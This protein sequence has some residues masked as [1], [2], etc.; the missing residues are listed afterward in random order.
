[1][2]GVTE[3]KCGA[4]TETM[5]MQRLPHLGSIPYITT[6]PRHYCG[7]QQELADRSLI[8]M[9]SERLC[10]CLTNTEV[11]A[12]SHLLDGA[13]GPQGRSYRRYSRS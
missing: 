7:Y 3:K 5:T 9:F 8:Y 4:D 10:Q 12:H 6:K 13:Q 2:E 1:M 11:F